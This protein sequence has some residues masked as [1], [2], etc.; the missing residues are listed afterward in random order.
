MI[1]P[2][3]R[4]WSAFN[5]SEAQPAPLS[6]IT[7]RVTISNGVKF[8]FRHGRVAAL[9]VLEPRGR[10]S[11]RIA[12]RADRD[13]GNE[14]REGEKKRG[15]LRN[16]ACFAFLPFTRHR[17]RSIRSRE[18]AASIDPRSLIHSCRFQPPFCT[19]FVPLRFHHVET[20]IGIATIF[21]SISSLFFLFFFFLFFAY[22]LL[23]LRSKDPRSKI[24]S[25]A[26]KNF[27]SMTKLSQADFSPFFL[28]FFLLI[29]LE[30]SEKLHSAS[31]G[32]RSR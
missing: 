11:R 16:R 9:T 21:Y 32:R 4:N 14:E 6:G 15:T 25:V 1:S 22:L 17:S 19:P 10:A 5:L 2:S 27:R 7:R 24:Q 31:D 12:Q 8:I 28:F 13:R 26:S 3:V 30:V 18:S 29:V 20:L 23:L